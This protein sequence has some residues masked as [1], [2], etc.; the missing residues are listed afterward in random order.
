MRSRSTPPAAVPDR[1]LLLYDL[2][3]PQIT[4][5]D[6]KKKRLIPMP[7]PLPDDLKRRDP[8]TKK[9]TETSR[10]FRYNKFKIYIFR[11]EFPYESLSML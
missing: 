7:D 8:K 3:K 4:A 6:M 5:V 1:N 9:L 2:R 11:E 10:R